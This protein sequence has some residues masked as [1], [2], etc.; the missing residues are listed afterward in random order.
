LYDVFSP[1]AL[2]STGT[3]SLHC[4]WLDFNVRIYLSTGMSGTYVS[5]TLDGPGTD[6]LNYNLYRDA[7]Y[8]QIWGDGTGGTSY[9]SNTWP[10]GNVINLI[11]Y[12]RITAGQDVRAGLYS[13]TV[14][15]TVTF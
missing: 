6:V 7:A 4:G 13:D 2:A 14:V 8:T 11:V 15:V 9:Y 12:G 10:T 1:T 5:R 3:V